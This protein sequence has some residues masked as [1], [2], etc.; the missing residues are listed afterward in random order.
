MQRLQGSFGLAHA[1]SLGTHNRR[2]HPRR[3]GVSF[4]VRVER[5]RQ[6]KCRFFNRSTCA[7]A[8][9][10]SLGCARALSLV[11]RL[12]SLHGLFA[13][14]DSSR[15]RATRSARRCLGPAAA[16]WCCHRRYQHTCATLPRPHQSSYDEAAVIAR[17]AITRFLCAV[18]SPRHNVYLFVLHMTYYRF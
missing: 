3:T 12:S 2:T 7:I 6:S 8:P 5:S 1:H 10:A 11:I 18:G 4:S 9:S 17:G 15:V 16:G 14:T 13:H